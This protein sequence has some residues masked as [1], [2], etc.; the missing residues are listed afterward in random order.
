MG[1]M[2][3]IW[4]SAVDDAHELGRTHR[5]P[6]DSMDREQILDALRLTDHSVSEEMLDEI[7]YAYDQGV[8]VGDYHDCDV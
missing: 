5:Q 1:A 4:L 3:E 7:A 8:R 2:K 6:F